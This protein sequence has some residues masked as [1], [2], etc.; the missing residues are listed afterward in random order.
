MSTALKRVTVIVG[1]V[2]LA[3]GLARPA[4]ASMI[5]FDEMGLHAGAG[6]DPWWSY[7]IKGD[8]LTDQ[9]MSFGVIFSTDTDGVAYIGGKLATG[10]Y[11]NINSVPVNAMGGPETTLTVSFVDP[12]N[13]YSPATASGIS[14]LTR[15]GSKVHDLRVIVDAYDA[16]GNW[17]ETQNL[18]GANEATLSF[19]SGGI[20]SLQFYDFGGDGH[21]IDNLNFTIDQPV[22]PQSVPEPGTVLFLA[23]GLGVAGMRRFRRS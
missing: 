4:S 19:S 17:L 5:T 15:D 2:V 10:N 14:V 23:A 20:A 13:G 3:F 12:L 7:H 9:L 6:P 11:L 18:F 1:A 8:I 16:G 22:P 21:V